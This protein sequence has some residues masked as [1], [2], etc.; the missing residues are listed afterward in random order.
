LQIK[1]LKDG[2]YSSWSQARRVNDTKGA[3]GAPL[4][5]SASHRDYP[6]RKARLGGFG[7]L[8]VLRVES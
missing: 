5:P 7:D 4:I 1:K 8:G 2:G 3:F 6:A